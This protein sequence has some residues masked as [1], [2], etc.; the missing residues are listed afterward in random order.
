MGYKKYVNDY[1]KE[2]VIKPNGKPGV[3]AVYKG[4]YFRFSADGDT[5]KKARI[6]LAGLAALALILTV[7]PLFYKS[8]GSRTLYV[9]LPHVIALL[10]LVHLLLGVYSFCFCKTPMIRERKDK[11]EHRTVSSAAA[12]AC[13]LGVTSVAELINC[14]LSGFSLPDVIYLILLL[15][16]TAATGS[17]FL[18]RGLLKTEECTEQ[19]EKL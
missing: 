8:S 10:P 11:S 1:S 19:G 16:A 2:Y 17:I 6:T 3:I 13:I 12:S 15:A 14:F 9:A 5:L 18:L 7:I 4:K